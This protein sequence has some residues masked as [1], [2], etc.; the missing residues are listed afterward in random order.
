[1]AV[2]AGMTVAVYGWDEDQGRTL[3]QVAALIKSNA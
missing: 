2:S 3:A 1:M